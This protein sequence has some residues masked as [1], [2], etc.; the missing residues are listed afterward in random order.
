MKKKLSFLLVALLGVVG[1]SMATFRAGTTETLYSWESP[2]G[3]PVESGGKAAYVNGVEPNRLNYPNGDYYT[4]CLNGKKGNIN[5]ATASVNAGAIQI[6]LDKP[7]AAGDKISITGYINKN[8]TGKAASAYIL[9]SNDANQTSENFG[10]EANI[11][12]VA[13]G[14]ITTKEVIVSAEAAG[15]TSFKMTR[16]KADTNLFITKLTITRE[17]EEE[18]PAATYTVA[19]SNTDLFGTS[20]DPANT[21]NDMTLSE[22]VYSWS[23]TDVTL[24]ANSVVE[25]K[26]CENHAWQKAYPNTN[27][28]A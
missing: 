27:Y 21:A 9:Y 19:G 7:L 14:A 12:P 4:M 1:I 28:Q 22:G 3:T 2:D 11:D 16:S 5:D 23:K 18:A 25:F 10:D 20:W 24:P 6:T 15:S 17:V 8:A 13:N 26:V